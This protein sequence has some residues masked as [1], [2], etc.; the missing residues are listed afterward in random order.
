MQS[1]VVPAVHRAFARRVRPAE[2]LA[3]DATQIARACHEMA[4]RFHRG[5]KLI[6]FANGG[7]A[8]DAQ[9]VVVEFVHPVIVGKRALPAISLTNDAA[10]LT[11]IA[12]AEGFDE[13][14][15]AQLR[16][17]AAPEDIALGLSVDGRCANVRRGLMTARDLG[18]LTVGL[19]GGDGGDIARDGIADHVVVA[20]SDDPCIVKEVHVTIY[21]IL[22]ELVHVFFEQPGLLEPESVR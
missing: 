19:L 11:G 12:R 21:H 1:P 14:F 18:L 6:V 22:W 2:A 9:H 20:R 5:G 3:G 17:L 10:T 13:V 15:A 7:P 4:V 8:T 16:L